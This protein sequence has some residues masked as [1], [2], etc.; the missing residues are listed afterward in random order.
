MSKFA[1]MHVYPFEVQLPSVLPSSIGSDGASMTYLI[2]AEVASLKNWRVNKSASA[3]FNVYGTE[4]KFRPPLVIADPPGYIKKVNLR[5]LSRRDYFTE[6]LTRAAPKRRLDWRS[7]FE[8]SET[9][10]EQ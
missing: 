3:F 7:D 6:R 1:G 5:S 8:Q 4:T 9:V 10:P 2:H